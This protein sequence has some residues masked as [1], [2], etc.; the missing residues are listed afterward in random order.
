MD[1]DAVNLLLWCLTVKMAAR[2][3]W[4]SRKPSVLPSLSPFYAPVLRM[5]A[6]SHASCVYTSAPSTEWLPLRWIALPLIQS[7]MYCSRLVGC[8]GGMRWRG[9]RCETVLQVSFFSSP[10]PLILFQR[11]KLCLLH[12][13]SIK[14]ASHYLLLWAVMATFELS[15]LMN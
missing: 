1:R 9:R 5:T 11:K 8:A 7:E 12:H 15:S 6:L 10:L 14:F 13:L 2:S 4:R 3:D